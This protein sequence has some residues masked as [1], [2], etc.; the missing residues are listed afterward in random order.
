[1]RSIADPPTR[2]DLARFTPGFG[3]RFVVTMDLAGPGHDEPGALGQFQ[4]L[5]EAEG[6]VPVYLA[7]ESAACANAVRRVLAAPVAAHRAEMGLLYPAT[8]YVEALERLVDTIERLFGAAPLLCRAAVPGSATDPALLI[9]CGLAIDCSARPRCAGPGGGVDF[10]RHPLAPYWLDPERTFLEL[11]QTTVFWGMLRR[12]GDHIAPLLP[13]APR[14]SRLLARL[15]LFECVTLSPHE[16]DVEQ[17]IRAIDM[18]L[19]DGLPLLVITAG[20]PPA[21]D[22]AAFTDWWQRVF[23]YLDLRGVLNTGIAALMRAV[24]R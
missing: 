8:I 2:S 23:A 7:D 12:Q 24:E 5:C 10:R 9:E 18:A 11:P 14:W 19:D 1:M 3:Q 15:G 22:V 13:G 4:C 17:A 16:A 20:L 21:E 6:V